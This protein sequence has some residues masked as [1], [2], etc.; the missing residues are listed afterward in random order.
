MIRFD[1]SLKYYSYVI[2]FNPFLRNTE[3][4]LIGNRASKYFIDFLNEKD[5]GDDLLPISFNFFIE[6][7]V[8]INKQDDNVSL[9]SYLGI[10][11]N[12]RLN[13]H[14]DYEYFINSSDE[15]KYKMVLNGVLY[16]LNYWK[17]NLKN[18]KGTPLDLI[19]ENYKSKLI[20]GN[21]FVENISEKYIKFLN[22]FKFHFMR[23][24]FYGLKEKHIYFDT[25][26]IEKYLNNNLYKNNYGKSI[27]K[28][29]FSYDIF[30][31]DNTG[32]KQYID[33]EKVYQFGKDK[34]L[35]IMEQYDSKLFFKLIDIEAMKTE[36]KL[37][38]EKRKM[39]QLEYFFSGL[40]NAI[41]RIETMKRRPKEF[42]YNLFYKVMDKLLKEYIR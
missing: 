27:N 21:Y 36:G 24:Y 22:Y 19:I 16:L 8:D 29:F 34:D 42:D 9:S 10:P 14:F 15:I 30:D 3:W 37:F 25:N 28:L 31:F 33:N 39:E 4:D 6:K 41:N 17:D 11:K 7:E 18:H 35:S 5:Y 1:T 12:A 38:N 20:N 23:H 26:D 40:L 13:L 2:H 32:H